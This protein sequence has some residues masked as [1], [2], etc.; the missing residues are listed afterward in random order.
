MHYFKYAADTSH[1][2]SV[3]SDLIN[4]DGY[5]TIDYEDLE[6]ESGR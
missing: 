1:R 3:C 2:E 6:K 4:T 5:Y